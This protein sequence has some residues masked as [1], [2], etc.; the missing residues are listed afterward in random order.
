MLREL[1]ALVLEII[2]TAA[3]IPI[4]LGYCLVG[5]F[6]SLADDRTAALIFMGTVVLVLTWGWQAV[7]VALLLYGVLFFSNA[8]ISASLS[9]K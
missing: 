8:A 6:L 4:H 5:M 7:G 2:K 3:R 9:R 1:S